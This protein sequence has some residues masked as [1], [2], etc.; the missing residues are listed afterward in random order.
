MGLRKPSRRA[1][2]SPSVRPARRFEHLEDRRVMAVL[3]GSSTFDAS[4]F[5]DNI[6]FMSD[7]N[8]VGYGYAI[9]VDGQ[10]NVATGSGGM[11][12]TA[13]DAPA[14]FFSSLTEME[15][16]SVS[17]TVTATAILKILQTKPGGLNAALNTPLTAY[18]PTDWTPGANVQNIT[19]RH[20]LTHSSGFLEVGNAIG[21][22]FNS[23]GNSNYANLQN[24]V[25]AGLP[26]PTIAADGVYA[27]PRWNSSYNNAN[28]SLLAKVVLPKLLNPLIN[29]TAANY[30]NR[31]STSGVLYRNYVQSNILQPLGINADLKPTDGTPAKGYNLAT[32]NVT[33]GLSQSD[34]TNTGGAFGWKMSAR[35]LATF[36]DGIKRDNSILSASTRQMRD[37]QELGWFDGNDAFGEYFTHNGATSGGA[38][39]F[40]SQIYSMP[41]DV[42][43]SYLMN[44]EST[45][46]P[47]GSI[48]SMLKTGYVNAWT[49][50]TVLG[51]PGAD[52][53]VI[54]LDNS[55][56]RPS[57]EVVLNGQT[58]FT[59]WINT[60]DSLTLNGGFG[61]DT[62]TIEGFNA[63]I[64]LTINGGFG[65]DVVNVLPGVRNIEYVNGMTFNGGFGD[66]SIN[67]NDASNPYNNAVYSRIYTVGSGAVSRFMWNPSF[68]GNPAFFL[69]VTVGYS[70]VENLDVT[71]GGQNDVVGVVSKTS[72]ATHVKTGAGNDVI[73][74]GYSGGNLEAFDGLEVNG[75]SGTDTIRLF[76]HNKTS[77]EPQATAQYDVAANSVSRYM[78]SVGGVSNGEPDPVAV[79][80]AQV[81]NLELTTTDLIDGIRVHSTPSGQTTIHGGAGNDVLNASPNEKNLENVD[82]LTFY[83][84]AGVD[85]IFLNDQNNPYSYP[86]ASHIYDVTSAGVERTAAVP[87]LIWALPMTINVGYSGVEDM[88]L[89]TGA[90]GDIVN[91]QSVPYSN[92]TIQTGDGNDVV[93]ASSAAANMETVDGLIVDGGA[94]AD[95]LNILDQNNPYELPGGGNYTITPDSVMRYAEHVLFDNVAVPVEV[96]FDNVENLS[97]AAG[98]LGDE[99]NVEGDAGAGTLTLDGNGGADEF[100]LPSPAFETINIQGDSPLFAPGDSLSLNG[101]A[102]YSLDPIPGLY[103]VGSGAYMLGGATVNYSGIEQTDAQEQLYGF[104][105]DFD[106]NGVVNGD[107]LTDAVLGWNTRFGADLDGGSFLDWQRNLGNGSPIVETRK[108]GAAETVIEPAELEQHGSEGWILTESL[109]ETDNSR[110]GVTDEQYV[111]A[112]R[113][114][115]APLPQPLA[116]ATL[117]ARESAFEEPEELEERE[118]AAISEA[119][120]DDAFAEYGAMA[121]AI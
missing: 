95:T 45:N 12:R 82:N 2:R 56:L 38:G 103:A 77:G 121:G 85:R 40:R 109:V 120:W 22:D 4:V 47:G 114:A 61:D 99:F 104:P 17:K 16:S 64:D 89:K 107:D 55:G 23:Y 28:F 19:L 1:K 15:I 108:L 27:T 72:G 88:T 44:S 68:P 97:V 62:F 35:E 60:L 67:I 32:A 101:D 10:V 13:A 37:D 20:L 94:G 34:L 50:L 52:N 113:D 84:D 7:S 76:D 42:E 118:S 90:H 70:G 69:P 73:T 81:E 112:A 26:A 79:D 75:Q 24:L 111:P 39:N 6:E 71:T 11:Q 33:P 14:E 87:N 92:A 46:L 54:R 105:G 86:A 3:T 43:V 78:A 31:D 30:A 18:L 102:M 8:A 63:G 119:A 53:F 98:N 5:G 83:G 41:G 66:D 115:L 117:S 116:M 96:G 58:E 48:S 65:N 91:V 106:G 29:L 49:D 57:I 74:V 80:F 100:I 59:H 36:L 9:N 25:Q 110:T 21:V 93:N 51:T